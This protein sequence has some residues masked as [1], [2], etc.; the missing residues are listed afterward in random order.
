MNEEEELRERLAAVDVP[1]SRIELD[2]LLRAGRRRAFRRRSTRAVGGVALATAV[3]LL[4]PS[5]LN[6]AGG[7]PGREPVAGRADAP[8]EP[9]G[10]GPT[11]AGPTGAEPTGAALTSTGPTEPT[12]TA[13]AGGACRPVELPVPAG[14]TGVTAVAVDP[15]GRYVLGTRTVGQDF[16]SLLWTD[17]RPVALPPRGTSVQ[18]TAVNAA[19]VVV[20]LV[21]EGQ[22][23]YVFRY[24]RGAYTMLR[25]PAGSWHP[26]P[27][28]AVNAAGDVVVNVEP[29]GNS[30]GKD[31]IVLLW[32]A[33]T[34][35]AVRLPL[36]AGANAFAVTDDGT[37][38][39]ALYADGVA[40]A[41][42]TWTRQGEGRRLAAPAGRTGAAYAARGDWATG[43]L[44]PSRD[45]ALWNLRTG[46]VTTPVGRGGDPAGSG[47]GDAV[48]AAGWVVA[49]GMLF[50][51]GRPV[52]L[53]VPD[54]QQGRAAA[55]SDT[56][57]VVGQVLD[58]S[59]DQQLGPRGWRC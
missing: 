41:A 3:L 44:W 48:N 5:I 52:E 1:A 24:E 16:R 20:G 30:G 57:L 18:A 33:G 10:T 28:P 15:T 46:K 49:G 42:Y 27:A 6:R 34:T 53:P 31:S 32:P 7:Q 40:T 51:D 47:P 39:G 56:G 23:E 8:T 45:A 55:L 54:G 11:G 37:I 26:F 35:K 14:T 59:G 22:Q 4:V 58:D 36:P 50:R 25:M 21:T 19:G 43:G 2:G 38:V 29:S 12:G 17:G 13:R 9:T